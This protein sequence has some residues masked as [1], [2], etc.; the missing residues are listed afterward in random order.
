MVCNYDCD[1]VL[2]ML[3]D[4]VEF[5]VSISIGGCEETPSIR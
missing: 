5:I 1:G 3:N 2:C 4:R